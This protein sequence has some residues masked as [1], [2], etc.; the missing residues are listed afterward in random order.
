[1]FEFQQAITG[2]KVVHDESVIHRAEAAIRLHG[3]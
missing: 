1:M 3:S 2:Y